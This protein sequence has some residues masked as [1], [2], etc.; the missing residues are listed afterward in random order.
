MSK[1][2]DWYPAEVKPVHVGFYQ[3]RYAE[4]EFEIYEPAQIPDYWDGKR[5]LLNWNGNISGEIQLLTSLPW[6]GL[7]EPVTE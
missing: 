1:Y 4:H 6:R 5:W 7:K 3:R 2:T